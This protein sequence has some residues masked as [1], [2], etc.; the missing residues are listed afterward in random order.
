MKANTSEDQDVL[1]H[2]PPL[3]EALEDLIDEYGLGL[4]QAAVRELAEEIEEEEIEEERDDYEN[5]PESA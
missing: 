3:A 4:V 2:Y 5:M 1:V